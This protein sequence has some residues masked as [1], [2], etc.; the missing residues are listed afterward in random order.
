MLKTFDQYLFCLFCPKYLK[1]PLNWVNYWTGLKSLLS[2]T[3]SSLVRKG[4]L[5]PTL[6]FNFRNDIQKA[7]NW[8]EITK[9]VLINYIKAF[10]TI[11]HKTLLEKLVL[12]HFS[13]RTIKFIMSCLSKWHQYVQIVDQTSPKSP[14]HFGVPQGSILGPIV[15]NVYVAELPSCIDSDSIQHVLDTTIYRTCRPNGILL[16]ICQLK[17]H[18]KIVWEWSPENG[19]VFNND[20]LKCITFSSKGKVND[21]SYLISSNRKSIAEE[22]TIKL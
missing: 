17:N 15:F 6:L 3:L 2:T 4:H 11:N 19:I 14:V 7:L 1:K 10:N 22:T 8:N 20:K 21:K 18:I 13:N 16:E 9:S 5:T 12:L